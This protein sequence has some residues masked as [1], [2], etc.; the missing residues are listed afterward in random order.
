MTQGVSKATSGDVLLIWNRYGHNEQLADRFESEGGRV[1]VAENGYI[2]RDSHGRQ[3]YAIAEHG[4]NGSG[5]WPANGAHRW[6]ALGIEI[7]PW[8]Q[9]GS[10]VLVCP[11]RPFGMR[12]FAMPANWVNETVAVLRRHTK[13]PIRVRPHPG[14]WQQV[15]PQTP[16]RDDLAGAWAV[17]IW[18]SSTGVQALV[19]GIPVICTAPWWIC[20][21]AAC[22]RLAEIEA[23]PKCDDRTPA[24]ER[25]AWAQWT[26]DEIAAGEP[27]HHLLK[28]RCHGSNE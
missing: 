25:L 3:H 10:H 20:K 7:K 12:G 2:G 8:R 18:S 9:D 21:P 13:R 14:N 28:D 5:R 26:V 23:Q 16:L 15:A 19:A 6:A 1:L 11:N 4:H 24:F 17:V 22:Q 27:F